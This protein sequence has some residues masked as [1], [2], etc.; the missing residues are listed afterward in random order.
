[1]QEKNIKPKSYSNQLKGGHKDGI[2][3][4]SPSISSNET[5]TLTKLNSPQQLCSSIQN[6]EQEVN[7]SMAMVSICDACVV[8]VSGQDHVTPDQQNK[9]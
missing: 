9:T 4:D 2:E 1:L 8:S 6:L 3:Q 5:A 7:T